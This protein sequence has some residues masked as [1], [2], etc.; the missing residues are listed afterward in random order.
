V[1]RPELSEVERLAVLRL[2]FSVTGAPAV[3]V[4]VLSADVAAALSV[5][6]RLARTEPAGPAIEVHAPWAH[7]A[8]TMTINYTEKCHLG[9]DDR[10]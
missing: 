6:D 9:G 2:L 8:Q 3:T 7:F 1:S 4:E 5:L 10:G